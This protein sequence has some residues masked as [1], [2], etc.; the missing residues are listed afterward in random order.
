MYEKSILLKLL[1]G[2]YASPQGSLQPNL[3]LQSTCSNLVLVYQLPH[4]LLPLLIWYTGGQ[5]IFLL[6]SF[7]QEHT[8]IHC[9]TRVMTEVVWVLLIRQ[10]YIYIYIC[11]ATAMRKWTER[12]FKLHK[13]NVIMTRHSKGFI[14]YSSSKLYAKSKP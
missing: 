11:V 7:V 13:K 10:I 5:S 4:Y 9:T 3:W 2:A 8:H 12:T 6:R 1:H 14:T